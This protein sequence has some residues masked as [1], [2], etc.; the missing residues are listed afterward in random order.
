MTVYFKRSYL[1]IALIISVFTI[2]S[3]SEEKNNA[4][5]VDQ[6]KVNMNVHRYD[7]EVFAIDTNKLTENVGLLKQKDAGFFNIFFQ[8]VLPIGRDSQQFTAS[9][10]GFLADKRIRN[11]YNT[12]QIVHGNLSAFTA[13]M[14]QALKYYKHYFPTSKDVDIYTFI[15]EFGFQR[16]IFNAG[17]KDGIGLGLDMFLGADYPYKN[18]D[19]TNPSFSSYLI[20]T[21][22]KDHMVPKAVDLLIDD[23]LSGHQSEKLIDHM[24]TNGKKLYLKK[25]LLPHTSDTLIFE[26]TA[27]QMQ[28]LKD[29]EL[30]MWSFFRDQNLVY[31]SN[32]V[33]INKYINDSPNSPGMPDAAPGKTANYIGY[34]IISSY[35]KK[36][37][38]T[39]LDELVKNSDYQK[40][41]DTSG[42]KPA[43]K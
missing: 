3:C 5:N 43:R 25:L 31:E 16:F 17:A 22:N 19:P 32:S 4:P 8:N 1:I 28:W 38:Q 7:H 13:E 35:M 21:F 40:L 27:D 42:F 29:N 23:L 10:R 18:I 24:I 15:S 26:H 20:R 30:E 6:I 11:L 33:K 12:T 39:T 2:W 9:L 36:F 37:P 14:S 34:R 41:F